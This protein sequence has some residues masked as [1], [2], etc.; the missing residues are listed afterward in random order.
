MSS[1]VTKIEGRAGPQESS[2]EPIDSTLSAEI[3][4]Q[5]TAV[6]GKAEE[7]HETDPLLSRFWNWLGYIA[8]LPRPLGLAEYNA[9]IEKFGDSAGIRRHLLPDDFASG[10]GLMLHSSDFPF[11]LEQ[12][13]QR[14]SLLFVA[15]CFTL[16]FIFISIVFAALSVA[17]GCIDVTGASFMPSGFMLIS[18]ISGLGLNQTSTC[19][20]IETFAVLVGVY[21]SLPIFGAFLLI[22]A[23][24]NF[25]KTLEVANHVLLTRRAGKTTIIFRVIAS[26]GLLHTS[27]AFTACFYVMTKDQETG[28]AYSK[29]IDIHALCPTSINYSPTNCTYQ[30]EDD[31]DLYKYE[32]IIIDDNGKPKWNHQKIGILK[33]QL[34]ADKEIGYRKAMVLKTF[35]DSR[36]HLLDAHPE[37]GA[38]P[39]WI[40]AGVNALFTWRLQ[41]GKVSPTSDLSKFHCWQ[42][43]E[44]MTKRWLEEREKRRGEAD[45]GGLDNSLVALEEGSGLEKKD[46]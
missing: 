45:G 37:T 35:Y 5:L 33:V 34:E 43:S 30:L 17:G 39:T 36:Y 13:F 4:K 8:G 46:Q 23:L 12:F 32:C 15:V 41:E 40:N 26:N 16:Y 19:L 22:R 2:T 38:F 31:D 9:G 1:A 18:G 10:N 44:S 42:Y 25:G 14:A 27:P 11:S 21:A 7:A 3:G 20:W 6:P 24:S 29:Q 28:E